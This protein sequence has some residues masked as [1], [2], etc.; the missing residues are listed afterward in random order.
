[1]TK[2]LEKFSPYLYDYIKR[3]VDLSEFLSNEIG[4]NLKWY[5]PRISAGTACPLPHHKDSKPSFRIKYIEESQVWI[6]HCLGCSCHGTVIDFFMEYYGLSSAAEA[7]LFI[8]DKFGFKKTD[9]VVIDS[10]KDVKTRVNLQKKI[11][12]THVVAS[13]Q[14]FALLKKDYVKYNKWVAESYKTMNKALDSEDL[15][16]IESIGFEASKKMGEK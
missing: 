13:R 3:K 1:M 11:N 9:G 12:C 16:V 6:W 10:L 7:A 8:C 5:E 15:G 4:C 14:C 2:Q